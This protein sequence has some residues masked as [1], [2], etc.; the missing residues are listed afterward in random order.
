MSRPGGSKAKLSQ[1]SKSAGHGGINYLMRQAISLH[2]DQR[3]NDAVAVYRKILMMYPGNADALTNFGCALLEIGRAS[4]A[5]DRLH[6]AVAADA[7]SADAQSYLGNALQVAGDWEAA[8]AAY[9]A[10]LDIEP[11]P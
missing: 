1:I 6:E 9:R 5:I 2:Q 10:A 11:D 8:E 3:F 4:E 7:G